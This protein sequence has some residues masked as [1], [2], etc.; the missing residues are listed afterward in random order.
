MVKN[1]EFLLVAYQDDEGDE[2]PCDS[3]YEDDF[4]YYWHF[5][6]GGLF[7]VVTDKNP[8]QYGLKLEKNMQLVVST[9]PGDGTSKNCCG[10]HG[11]CDEDDQPGG[12]A[13]RFHQDGVHDNEHKFCLRNVDQAEQSLPEIRPGFLGA[14]HDEC[15][16][17][18]EMQFF[19][20]NDPDDPDG[21]E[22]VLKSEPQATISSNTCSTCLS[23]KTSPFDRCL[24]EDMCIPAPTAEACEGH[25]GKWCS[26]PDFPVCANGKDDW[27]HN[28]SRGE[29]SRGCSQDIC[30]STTLHNGK[31]AQPCYTQDQLDKGVI[32]TPHGCNYGS[33][34]NTC[35]L[36]AH[37]HCV[38]SD[39]GSPVA[40]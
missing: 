1:G 28:A 23:R 27:G 39:L 6:K 37:G 16:D 22:S 3:K 21:F 29:C 35:A 10:G 2:Q 19:G 24:S 9:I 36:D 13:W 8:T 31:Q 32:D 40:V 26:A 5:S 15:G 12:G 7:T 34:H 33:E 11:E 20:H 30:E 4:P 14:G 25:G 17:K 18:W 38:Y